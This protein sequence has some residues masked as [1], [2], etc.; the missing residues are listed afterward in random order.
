[1]LSTEGSNSG[2]FRIQTS[3]YMVMSPLR[4]ALQHVYHMMRPVQTESHEGVPSMSLWL[5]CESLLQF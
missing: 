5:R 2:G 1:M 3:M 4:G